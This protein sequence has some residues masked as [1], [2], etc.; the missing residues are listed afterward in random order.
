MI[1]LKPADI[2]QLKKDD[3][4]KARL[5]TL[6]REIEVLRTKDAKTPQSVAR[7]ESQEPCFMCNGVDHLPKDCP[8][9]FEMREHCNALGFPN[10]FKQQSQPNLNLSWRNNLG[11]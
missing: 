8:T 1:V 2:Y 5:E 9:Y 10:R 11:T 7:V 3:S 6:T 4:F